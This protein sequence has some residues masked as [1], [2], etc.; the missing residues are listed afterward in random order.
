M[1]VKYD[2]TVRCD[3]DYYLPIAVQT[4]QNNPAGL[5][6]YIA[7]MTVKAHVTDSDA[8]DQRSRHGALLILPLHFSA[9]EKT[10]PRGGVFRTKI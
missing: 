4:G 8:K 1:A 6:G 3:R 2:I 9:K 5:T 7:V 10:P